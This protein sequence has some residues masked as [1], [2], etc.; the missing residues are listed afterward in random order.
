M[1]KF[2]KR[3][4]RRFT[5]FAKIVE[6]V[7]FQ[8][9]KVVTIRWKVSLVTFSSEGASAQILKYL[10]PPRRS[11]LTQHGLYEPAPLSQPQ[12]FLFHVDA[13]IV[14][15]NPPLLLSRNYEV[16]ENSFYRNH[17]RSWSAFA[18]QDVSSQLWIARRKTPK[19]SS[20]FQICV[21]S[22]PWSNFGHWTVEHF[23]KVF[24]VIDAGLLD[25]TFFILEPSCPVW[26]LDLLERVGVSRSQIIDWN[27]RECPTQFATAF[28]SD[29]PEPNFE[30]FTRID[31][32]F[33]PIEHETQTSQGAVFLSR[34]SLG[35][36]KIQN[37]DDVEKVLKE[38]GV[39]VITPESLP[40]EQQVRFARGA[41]LLI[42][43][44]GSA[45]TLAIFM[46]RGGKVIEFHGEKR[47]N[48][49]NRQL[50]EAMGHEYIAVQQMQTSKFRN[51]RS[52]GFSVDTELLR[53]LLVAH[54]SIV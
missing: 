1:V 17:E 15:G 8:G 47:L 5:I 23:P 46:R 35:K 2:V 32:C 7:R 43:P 38:F 41:D 52:L 26:K 24:R 9:A 48:L 4:L 6:A 19:R 37:F 49:Y 39:A 10:K 29:Y 18:S 28:V 21:L 40:L 14:V 13:P 31:Q 12:K 42:G 11:G 27:F 50:A 33:G 54:T 22:S 44:E 16:V 36:R 51:T 20:K 3:A 45:F 25:S 30:D 53:N 34:Q